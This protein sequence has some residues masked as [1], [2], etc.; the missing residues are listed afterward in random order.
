[1]NYPVPWV[2]GRVEH[3]GR[4]IP[5]REFALTIEVEERVPEVLGRLCAGDELQF[6]GTQAVDAEAVRADPARNVFVVQ[7]IV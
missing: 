5:A 1:M 7:A 4:I 3:A 6:T 2:F